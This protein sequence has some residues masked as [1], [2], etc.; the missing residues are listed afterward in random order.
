MEEV[1]QN[2]VKEIR[3]PMQKYAVVKLRETIKVLIETNKIHR[4]SLTAAIETTKKRYELYKRKE[5]AQKWN[6]KN[7]S[8]KINNVFL[9]E[10]EQHETYHV[11][12]GIIRKLLNECFKK[13]NKRKIPKVYYNNRTK[14]DENK[15][16]IDHIDYLVNIQ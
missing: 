7:T 2:S 14:L 1:I 11:L 5:H 3:G 16:S 8:G 15:F 6:A 4:N 12:F 10:K 9:I 13:R